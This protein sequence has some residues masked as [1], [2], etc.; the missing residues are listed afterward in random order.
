[1]WTESGNDQ[2]RFVSAL[3]RLTGGG[4]EFGGL[5][6]PLVPIMSV[7]ETEVKLKVLMDAPDWSVNGPGT[8]NGLLVI[9][10]N[11]GPAKASLRSTCWHS[12]PTL[13]SAS[14]SST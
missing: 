1:M 12:L 4:I 7:V 2:A 5:K 14:C 13:A 10:G 3:L 8:N 9:R 6:K 11:R